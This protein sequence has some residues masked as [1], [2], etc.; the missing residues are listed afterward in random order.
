MSE[1]FPSVQFGQYVS[2][3]FDCNI[4]SDDATATIISEFTNSFKDRI[5][6]NVTPKLEAL[7][8][9]RKA[10]VHILEHC[11]KDQITEIMSNL[12]RV[13]Q[14]IVTATQPC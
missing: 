3:I 8:A 11:N 7:I 6:A 14:D 9:S 2:D 5:P 1:C 12:D 4:D 10:K 13:W